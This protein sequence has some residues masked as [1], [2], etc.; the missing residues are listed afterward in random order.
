[1]EWVSN[2]HDVWRTDPFAEGERATAVAADDLDT[3]M[4]A[5]PGSERGRV[6]VRQQVP[7][8]TALQVE[9]DRVEALSA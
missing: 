2:L 9:M 5:Q 8:A 4:R 7:R 1:M 3:W 6:P